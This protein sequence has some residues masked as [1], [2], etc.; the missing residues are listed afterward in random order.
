MGDRARQWAV[1]RLPPDSEIWVLILADLTENQAIGIH[2]RYTREPL[3]GNQ[4]RIRRLDGAA[5]RKDNPNALP[6]SLPVPIPPR[7]A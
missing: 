2:L 1:E 7:P 3:E 4:Y 5:Y 6:D